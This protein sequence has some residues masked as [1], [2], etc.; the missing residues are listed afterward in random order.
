MHSVITSRTLAWWPCRSTGMIAEE[1]HGPPG[2]CCNTLS[3]PSALSPFSR[4]QSSALDQDATKG[5]PGHRNIAIPGGDLVK[6]IYSI[7]ADTGS[8]Q[9][10]RCIACK[11]S[12]LLWWD[13]AKRHFDAPVWSSNTGTTSVQASDRSQAGRGT[14]PLSLA[15]DCFE[16]GQSSETSPAS[17]SKVL[18]AVPLQ[19][20]SEWS[21]TGYRRAVMVQNDIV[22]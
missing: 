13:W 19:S 8:L 11:P 12:R 22:G 20:I 15:T 3:L 2:T 18:K 4:L 21:L 5:H 14:K 16:A 7:D 17:S 10:R 1:E 9:D 6:G